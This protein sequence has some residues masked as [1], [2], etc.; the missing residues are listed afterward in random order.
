MKVSGGKFKPH[1]TLVKFEWRSLSVNCAMLCLCHMSR[2]FSFLGP[3]KVSK[4][5]VSE[6]S[7]TSLKLSW[8]P[9]S[10]QFKDFRV[11]AMNVINMYV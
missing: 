4:L 11:T 1:V 7:D 6:N 5:T 9:P 8:K 10:G 2:L 3:G